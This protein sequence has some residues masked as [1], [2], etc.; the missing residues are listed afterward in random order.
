MPAESDLPRRL[1]LDESAAIARKRRGRNIAMLV[2]L[3]AIVVLFYAI[4][5]VKIA[6]PEIGLH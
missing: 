4:S 6:K 2:V 5:M 1:T 3:V